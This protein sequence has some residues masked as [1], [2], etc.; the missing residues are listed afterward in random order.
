MKHE[1]MKHRQQA[2]SSK[3]GKLPIPGIDRNRPQFGS[4]PP[5]LRLAAEAPLLGDGSSTA[6]KG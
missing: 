4:E 1:S 6:D 5:L 2:A 3:R